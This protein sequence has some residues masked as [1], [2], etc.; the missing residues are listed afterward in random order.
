MRLTLLIPSILLTLTLSDAARAVPWAKPRR[1]THAAAAMHAINY[2]GGAVL[3]LGWDKR[4]QYTDPAAIFEAVDRQVGRL[5]MF[6]GR[7]QWIAVF[8]YAPHRA[9]RTDVAHV[10]KYLT[11]EHDVRTLAITEQ[12]DLAEHADDH[13]TYVYYAPP[14]SLPRADF[15]R[16][17]ARP[18][19]EVVV[20]GGGWSVLEKARRA[21]HAGVPVTYVRS[22]ARHYGVDGRFGPVDAWA[23][24]MSDGEIS[25]A[26]A[27]LL[28]RPTTAGTT[29]STRRRSTK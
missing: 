11:D 10:M 4:A 25:P 16:H 12:P 13:L 8:A 2:H 29:S 3:F 5:N 14:T 1:L 15:L 20:I 6:Y 24:R 21:F 9:D 7:G 18:L 19:R 27:P 26:C 22:A 17:H 28:L 23:R